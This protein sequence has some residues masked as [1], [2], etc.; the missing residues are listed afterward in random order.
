[1]KCC[2]P[3]SFARGGEGSIHL[4]GGGEED[5]EDSVETL[6][7]RLQRRVRT[8]ELEAAQSQTDQIENGLK[9]ETC[10]AKNDFSG[11]KHYLLEARKSAHYYDLQLKQKSNCSDVYRKLRE[12]MVNV[13]TGKSFRAA[14]MTLDDL[15]KEMPQAKLDDIMD[16]LTDHAITVNQQSESLSNPLSTFDVDEKDVEAE[17]RELLERKIQLPSVPSSSGTSKGEKSSPGILLKSE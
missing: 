7:N 6:L 16:A 8:L 1:M 17:V 3:W 10:A 14:S 15:Q 12:A 9:A 13:E 5:R 2:F 11:T 4:L